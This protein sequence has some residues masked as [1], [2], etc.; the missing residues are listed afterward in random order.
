MS[1]EQDGPLSRLLRG[2]HIDDKLPPIPPVDR[3]TVTPVEISAEFF[4]TTKRHGYRFDEAE[5]SGEMGWCC[6]DSNY[7]G[8]P[9]AKRT[10]LGYGKTQDE[11]YADYLRQIDEPKPRAG[12]V[13]H[14]SAFEP[15][16]VVD[17]RDV[18][19][20]DLTDDAQ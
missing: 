16:T 4:G 7:D 13:I 18:T 12:R 19:F 20:D 14:T 2:L 15:P 10:P 1:T 9:D 5:V 11:A 3:I 8:S 6:S 17:D